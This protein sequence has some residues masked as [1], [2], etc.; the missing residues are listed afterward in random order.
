MK[1]SKLNHKIAKTYTYICTLFK[2]KGKSPMPGY[3]LG[4]TQYIES[5]AENKTLNDL[6]LKF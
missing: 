5:N 6:I 2:K 1:I 3:K 4:S